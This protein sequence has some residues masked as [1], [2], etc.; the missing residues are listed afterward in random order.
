MMP[1]ENTAASLREPETPQ[2][3]AQTR[4]LVPLD[5][6]ELA[7]KALPI[8][9]Y[10]C[11][12]L[13]AELHLARVL[14][15]VITPFI[16][17][18]TYVPPEIYQQMAD[19]QKSQA[20]RY[21]GQVTASAREHGVH[22]VAT[23]IVEFNDTASALLDLADQL[24]PHLIVMTTHGRTGLARFALGSVADR[25]VRGSAT[26]VL[27]VRAFP[28][29][30]ATGTAARA[31]ELAHAL[32]P[33]DGSPLGEAPLV[34]GALLLA[35]P[36]FRTITLLRVVDP[37]DGNEGRQQA[38]RYLDEVRQRLLERLE[39]RPCIVTTRIRV[40]GSPAQCIVET[41]AEESCDLV[42]MATHGETGFGRLAFG[43]TTDR[44][45]RDSQLPL[46]LIH[47]PTR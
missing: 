42:F 37:R 39:G 16:A 30:A 32:V 14:P 6:S 47:P 33:L 22:A 36:V 10:L 40:G 21:L 20:I 24:Q 18:E 17:S 3:R 2:G 25:V 45:I 1:S 41:A 27:L 35:G 46:L 9:E 19:Q 11:R 34:S 29:E 31:G 12:Q 8:A 13:G 26:P 44:V 23:S 4:V 38:E 5:G 7:A 28:S 43:S 15:S